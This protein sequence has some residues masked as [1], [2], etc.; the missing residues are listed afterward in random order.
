MSFPRFTLFHLS[1]DPSILGEFREVMK[2]K[3]LK[4]GRVAALL[5]ILLVSGLIFS[6]IFYHGFPMDSVIFRLVTI[7]ISLGFLFI[8][9]TSFRNIR[10]ILEVA[11]TL[12]L[13]S[14]VGMMCARLLL[15]MET[16][17]FYLMIN[18]TVLSI[19]F[20][21]IFASGGFRQSLVVYGVPLAVTAALVALSTEHDRIIYASGVNLLIIAVVGIVMSEV[22]YRQW[23][24]EFLSGRTMK[25]QNRALQDRNQDIQRELDLARNI[26]AAL[27]PSEVPIIHGLKIA[28]RFDP[29]REVG[30]DLY[31][32]IYYRDPDRLGIFICDVTGHGVP[33]A[34][35]AGMVKSLIISAPVDP[36]RPAALL[37][38]INSKVLG[39]TQENF[40]TACNV[41][42]DRKTRTCYL[43]RAG[44]SWPLLIRDGRVQELKSRGRILGFFP[45][46]ES[47]VLSVP[48]KKGDRIIL[49]TDGLSE[50]RNSKGEL[51][52]DREFYRFLE[53]Y[54]FLSLDDYL[55]RLH[56]EV[57]NFRG[58]REITDDACVV[59]VEITA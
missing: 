52:Q 26:Q 54:S 33:A 34:L 30:G 23:F 28:T 45:I 8:S 12:F 41:I 48:L 56:E 19:I 57:E 15:F 49:Y 51:F 13:M 7:G 42:Y 53:S 38:Y 50:T 18:G 22:R 16:E 39:R 11:Y 44:H 9:L 20:V 59:G 35:I 32:F 14:I 1:E 55:D 4:Q 43:A 37:E 58:A 24:R 40:I 10:V 29:M 5:V 46:I 3:T 6:D 31:D 25:H 36:Y 21:F 2:G 17:Y 27:I 47:D